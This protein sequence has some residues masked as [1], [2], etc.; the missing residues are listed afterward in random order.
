M[1]WFIGTYKRMYKS[2]FPGYHVLHGLVLVLEGILVTILCP[3]GYSPT[4]LNDFS[5][6]VWRY[7]MNHGQTRRMSLS[8]AIYSRRDKN[9]HES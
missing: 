5:D 6:W 3:F 9:N 2:R 4:L 7:D 1:R 8:E